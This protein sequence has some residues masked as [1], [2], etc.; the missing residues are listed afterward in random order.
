MLKPHPIP[1]LSYFCWNH[2]LCSCSANWPSKIIC[3][4][5]EQFFTENCNIRISHVTGVGGLQDDLTS[6]FYAVQKKASS[7][8]VLSV[9]PKLKRNW[10]HFSSSFAIYVP[11]FKEEGSGQL[12]LRLK[13]M[14]IFTPLWKV[15]PD[16]HKIQGSLNFF[17]ETC[18]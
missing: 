12:T 17:R 7:N 1:W 10:H 15:G 14:D 3:K 18:F 4:D 6:T 8:M 11:F 16:R 2:S 5:K 9:K 13:Y